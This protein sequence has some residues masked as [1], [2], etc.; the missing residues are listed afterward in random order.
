MRRL[1]EVGQEWIFDNPFLLRDLRQSSRRGRLWLTLLFG[2]GFPAALVLVVH[3]LQ[4]RYWPELAAPPRSLLG[5]LLLCL[6]SVA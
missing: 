5:L 4:Q 3:Y 6:V 2:S 1:L